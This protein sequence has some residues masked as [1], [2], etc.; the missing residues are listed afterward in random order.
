MKTNIIYRVIESDGTMG[1]HTDYTDLMKA[2]EAFEKTFETA[3][4]SSI[5]KIETTKKFFKT[6]YKRTVLNS[7]LF[8]E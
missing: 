5:V 8:E 4:T 6:S 7:Y 3:M 1:T 2:I